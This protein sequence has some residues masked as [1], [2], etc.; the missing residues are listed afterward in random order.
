MPEMCWNFA[1]DMIESL[2]QF[3]LTL[4]KTCAY[5][6]ELIL[7]VLLL[8]LESFPLIFYRGQIHKFSSCKYKRSF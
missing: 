4:I 3:N 8:A 5:K 2:G 1:P 7:E 6:L